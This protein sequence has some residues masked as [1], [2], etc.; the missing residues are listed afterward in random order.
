MKHAV[1]TL[2]NKK[3][4]EIELR[5]DLF[6]LPLRTDIL[7][8]VVTWQLAKRRSGT[9]KVQVVSEVSGTTK[10][11]F[12]QKGTGNA[13][14]GSLKGPHMVGGGVAHGPVNRDHGYKLN[15]KVVALGLKTALSLKLAEGSLKIVDTTVVG[16]AKTSELKATLEKAGIA[17]ALIVRGSADQDNFALAS[18]GIKDIDVLPQFGL[19]VYDI[20]RRKELV[21]TKHALTDLQN[22]LK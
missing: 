8:R 19:N 9:H 4:E 13:R 2:E 3:L 7:H 11:P 20:L 21:I 15:K 22:R 18:R 10:K 16:S 1:V 12:K 17:N 14:Q 5:E 6:G